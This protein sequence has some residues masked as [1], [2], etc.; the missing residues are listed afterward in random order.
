MILKPRRFFL[1]AAAVLLAA[2][3]AA[4]DF[5]A[6][7][8]SV[9]LQ[10]LAASG[11]PSASVAIVKDGRIAYVQAYGEARLSPRAAARPGMRY[12]IGSISKQFTAAAIL[13]L[14]QDG[15]LS[16]DDPVARFLPEL[17]RAGDVTIRQLLSHTSGYQDYWP[18]D[19]V[20]PF[21]LEPVGAKDILDR[22]A[23][24]PL[25]FE[26][27]TQYQYSNTGYVIAGVI[28]ERAGGVPLPRLLRDRIFGPL[29]MASVFDVDESALGPADPAGYLRY[30]LGPLRAAPKEGKGWL[31]SAGELAMTAEDLAR[32]NVSVL[33]RTI[34]SPA[35]YAEMETEVR[36]K[37]GLGIRYG[38][39]IGVSTRENRRA[40]TH[41]GEVSGFS[42]TNVVFPDDRAAVTVLTNL[43][44]SD[45]AGE[46]ANRIAP[47]L[48][49]SKEATAAAESRARRVFEGLRRSKL[50]RSL[51]T[52]NA[53]SY[54]TPEAIR[55][56]AAGL[57]PLGKPVEVKQTEERDRGGLKFRGFDV[58][59]RRRTVRI[60][61]RDAPDGKIEQFQ[62]L[63][64]E[65]R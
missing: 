61:E 10:A 32:W 12:A 29:E 53:N 44:A 31:Q 47:L 46:I 64:R 11:V 27:G 6:E 36:L 60:W 51:F 3:P 22:W 33:D 39:G 20:P 43:D 40:L 62:I 4:A 59:L 41:G 5:Q 7:V 38:L 49:A 8:D 15:R 2:G 48:F 28:A 1:S 21:M 34:L 9:V 25:D 55:D 35:S 54:F 17:S 24:R 58:K 16:L 14:A 18:Q 63:P 50:D 42:A 23:R 45:G 52:A 65:P 57:G 19:Y 13:L 37:N 30:G 26:P 56:F